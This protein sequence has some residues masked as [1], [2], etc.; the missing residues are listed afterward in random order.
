MILVTLSLAAQAAT[1]WVPPSEVTVG[2]GIY[3]FAEIG[4]EIG[5]PSTQLKVDKD[6]ASRRFAVYLPHTSWAEITAKFEAGFGVKAS[7]DSNSQIRIFIDPDRRSHDQQIRKKIFNAVERAFQG[8]MREIT[9]NRPQTWADA[10]EER[11]TL[12]S[13]IQ[14]PARF[15][16][17]T[18]AQILR[19]SN[20]PKWNRWVVLS[21]LRSIGDW[22]ASFAQ[23]DDYDRL[24][25]DKKAVFIPLSAESAMKQFGLT[26]ADLQP[27]SSLFRDERL[28][29]LS[30]GIAYSLDWRSLRLICQPAVFGP[31][32]WFEFDRASVALLPSWATRLDSDL[33]PICAQNLMLKSEFLDRKAKVTVT[34][35]QCSQSEA[36]LKWAVVTGQPVISDFSLTS[37]RECSLHPSSGSPNLSLRAILAVSSL[38]SA[39][40]PKPEDQMRKV[41][42][43]IDKHAPA[44]NRLP[45]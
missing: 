6:L 17:M 34:P 3:T 16:V 22:I 25:G 7:I 37:D 14:T 15:P 33:S 39:S 36:L 44:N 26:I 21:R 9:M 18:E 13:D 42:E 19:G 38:T 8:Q 2:P 12:A 35:G 43:L 23:T 40:P 45:T 31:A 41:I 10:G 24:I 11:H 29:S 5:I 1:A 28:G 4:R 30:I 27:Q 20:D 32:D